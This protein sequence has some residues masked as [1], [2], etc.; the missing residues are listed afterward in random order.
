MR[1]SENIVGVSS[2][3]FQVRASDVSRNLVD[4]GG[5]VMVSGGRVIQRVLITCEVG[6]WGLNAVRIAFGRDA[7]ATIGHLLDLGSSL[8]VSN[9][10]SIRAINYIDGT[11]SEWGLLQITATYATN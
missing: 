1:V 10:A 2:A 7:T 6:K 4:D 5:L 9:P 3:T 8:V 11:G